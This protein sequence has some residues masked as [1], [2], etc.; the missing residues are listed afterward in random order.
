M[1]GDGRDHA[2]LVED[3]KV[4]LEAALRAFVSVRTCR[5]DGR[6][7]SSFVGPPAEAPDGCTPWF[8]A[9]KRAGEEQIFFGHW[10]ALGLY[11]GDG[12]TGLDT[13]CAWGGALTAIRLEDRAVYQVSRVE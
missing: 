9:R 8:M 11:L 7:C 4:V 13:G 2:A 3:P 10:A 5:A 1:Y 12:F 6:L